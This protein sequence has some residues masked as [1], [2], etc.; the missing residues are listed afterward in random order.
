MCQAAI[1]Q[2]A[3]CLGLQML[4]VIPIFADDD[5]YQAMSVLTAC[6]G[7]EVLTEMWANNGDVLSIEYTGIILIR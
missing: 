4:G 2:R 3:L 5:S 6:G 7:A 1:G